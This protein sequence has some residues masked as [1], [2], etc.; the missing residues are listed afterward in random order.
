MYI[1]SAT[2]LIAAGVFVVALVPLTSAGPAAAT[3]ARGAAHVHVPQAGRAVTGK[4]TRYV[5]TG[6]A[7]SCTSAAVVNAVAK[8]GLIRFR[9][10]P[11]HVTIRMTATAKVVN[12]SRRVV[13][14]QHERRPGR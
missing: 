3:T 4:A 5:G 9:C 2:G 14:D 6:T 7:S 11:G 8:G 13:L 1:R 12:T 10:G